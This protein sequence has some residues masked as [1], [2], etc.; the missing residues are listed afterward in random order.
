MDNNSRDSSNA[1]IY[2]NYDNNYIEKKIKLHISVAFEAGKRIYK[3]AAAVATALSLL[4]GVGAVCTLKTLAK[5]KTVVYI[6]GN[7]VCYLS[8]RSEYENAVVKLNEFIDS[9]DEVAYEFD[10]NITVETVEVCNQASDSDECYDILYTQLMNDYKDAFMIYSDGIPA[11][12]CYTY[13]EAEA[14]INSLKD[15]ISLKVTE[16]D[17]NV[18]NAELVNEF[19][20]KNEKCSKNDI[21]SG[22]ELLERLLSSFVN[23]YSGYAPEED[24]SDITLPAI[25]GNSSAVLMQADNSTSP[26]T[27]LS[28]LVNAAKNNAIVRGD[29]EAK[30]GN[31]DFRIAMTVTE[32]RTVAIAPM[33][34]YEESFDLYEGEIVLKT[35]GKNGQAEITYNVTYINGEEVLADEIS[36]VTISEAV[37]TVYSIGMKDPTEPTGKLVWP[38][39]D[40]FYLSSMYGINRG[41][42]L[43]GNTYHTGID[44]PCSYRTPVYAA[45]GGEVVFAGYSGSYGYIIK[46][47]HNDGIETWYAHLSYMNVSKGDRVYQGQ[48]IGE[49]GDTGRAYGYHLHFEVRIDNA[50][51]NPLEYLPDDIDLEVRCY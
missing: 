36:R 47:R 32:I 13:D 2:D 25:V 7:R 28:P 23:D 37:N 8:D 51:K 9:S 18:I 27:T 39:Q 14:V 33:I 49:V 12:A 41:S 26:E 19:E 45:D 21:Y 4:V 44:L 10:H 17:S 43:D 48:K 29:D 5:E 31:I 24:H 22:N 3:K 35:E 6:D 30:E 38:L 20:I 34:E 42:Y 15:E 46:L 40:D 11:G 50:A 16:W 1:K